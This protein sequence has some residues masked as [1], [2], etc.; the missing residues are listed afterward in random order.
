MEVGNG[1]SQGCT[2]ADSLPVLSSKSRPPSVE[3]IQCRK[4][5]WLHWE[6]LPSLRIITARLNRLIR[7]ASIHH[8][9]P[10]SLSLRAGTL[11]PCPAQ[12]GISAYSDLHDISAISDLRD[13]FAI[14]DLRDISAISDL[15]DISAISD[16]RDISTAPSASRSERTLKF[17]GQ[18]PLMIDRR[19]QGN[20]GFSKR[21]KRGVSTE[22]LEAFRSPPSPICA[23]SPLSPIY[24]ATEMSRNHRSTG[25]CAMMMASRSRRWNPRL[26]P[27]RQ[28]LGGLRVMTRIRRP[29]PLATPTRVT[30]LRQD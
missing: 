4:C 27:A 16:L 2:T 18:S 10:E 22:K 11:Q 15:R 23:I 25:R 7:A 29:L 17:G 3:G 5:P 30:R 13:I 8:D 20:E 1:M 19:N 14:S 21:L 9:I 6:A 28:L 12:A 24:L 26:A